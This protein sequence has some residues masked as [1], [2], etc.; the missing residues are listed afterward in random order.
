MQKNDNSTSNLTTAEVILVR[1]AIKTYLGEGKRDERLCAD[2][3][4]LLPRIEALY[5]FQELAAA[6]ENLK[7]GLKGSLAGGAR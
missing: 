6:H 5:P 2:L 3:R 1:H 4:K 7:D